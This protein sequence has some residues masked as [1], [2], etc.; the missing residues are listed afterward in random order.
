MI[1]SIL[2]AAKKV[3]D[4]ASEMCSNLSKKVETKKEIPNYKSLNGK[5]F[6]VAL[7]LYKSST[8][9]VFADDKK[10]KT[11]PARAMDRQ[12]YIEKDC[13]VKVVHAGKSVLFVEEVN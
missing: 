13:L 2:K 11:Y 12:A 5:E 3:K 6:L 7:P 1:D 4:E 8:G 10:E 9:T